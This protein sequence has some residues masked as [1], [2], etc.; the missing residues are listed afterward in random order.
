[1]N[2]PAAPERLEVS[3]LAAYTAVNGIDQL[4]GLPNAFLAA[5]T[6]VNSRDQF[7]IGT[8][9]FLAAYTAVNAS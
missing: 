8:M 9:N 7:A 2:A 5:Y 3:F 6:A 4:V 1:M